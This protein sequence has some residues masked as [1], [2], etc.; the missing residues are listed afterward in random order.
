MLIDWNPQASQLLF[1][2]GTCHTRNPTNA[3]SRAL[4]FAGKYKL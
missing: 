3:A 1:L 4:D 2:A